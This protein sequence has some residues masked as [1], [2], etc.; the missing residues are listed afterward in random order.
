VHLK[1]SELKQSGSIYSNVY[2]IEAK[3]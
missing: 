2:T 1:K 3:E